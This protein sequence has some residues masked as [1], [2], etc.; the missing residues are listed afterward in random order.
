MGRDGRV[1]AWSVRRDDS[2]RTGV[3]RGI[4]AVSVKVLL[5]SRWHLCFGRIGIGRVEAIVRCGTGLG[6]G[7]R[8]I[9]CIYILIVQFGGHVE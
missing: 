1:V 5:W 8:G 7:L 6:E 4:M 3:T 9:R 2:R